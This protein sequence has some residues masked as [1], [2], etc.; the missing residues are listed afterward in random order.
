MDQLT[1]DRLKHQDYTGLGRICNGYFLIHN[2][3][4]TKLKSQ[5]HDLPERQLTKAIIKETE[6]SVLDCDNDAS[7]TAITRCLRPPTTMCPRHRGLSR[8]MATTAMATNVIK[9]V[10]DALNVSEW[11]WDPG[12]QAPAAPCLSFAVELQYS[13]AFGL[14]NVC[15]DS[16]LWTSKHCG[17]TGVKGLTPS[18]FNIKNLRH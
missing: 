13:A 11:D 7:L 5:K 10:D 15:T 16:R 1:N 8:T 17:Y 9:H 6:R 12:R 2:H 18:S 3:D 14:E 4:N